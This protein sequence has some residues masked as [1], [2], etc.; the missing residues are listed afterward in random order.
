MPTSGKS[1]PPTVFIV[2]D[3]ESVRCSLARLVKSAGMAAVSFA[4]AQEFIQSYP[5]GAPGCLVLDVQMPEMSGLE[6]QERMSRYHIDLPVIFLTGYSEVPVSVRAMKHGAADFLQKPVD[7]HV[8]IET[9]SQAMETNTLAR[10]KSRIVKSLQQRL[11]RLTAR[12]RDV[13]EG[14][15]AGLLNKQIADRLQIAENTVKAHRG[16]VMEKLAVK[17]VAELVR[18]VTKA[19]S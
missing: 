11:D 1:A 14:V 12:E 4:S 2:D 8:L 9:I 7:E 17:S 6:L 16:R 15:L 18:L 5:C 10:E 19:G 3:D 13:M